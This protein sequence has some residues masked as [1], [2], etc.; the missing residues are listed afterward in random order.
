M[1]KLKSE[2]PRGMWLSSVRFD[3][4]VKRDGAPVRFH[5]RQKYA[6]LGLVE[7]CAEMKFQRHRAEL[8]EKNGEVIQNVGE[9]DTLAIQALLNDGGMFADAVS[10]S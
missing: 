2:F 1:L 9:P 4:I 10:D 5:M 7:H 3:F 8:F 6:R